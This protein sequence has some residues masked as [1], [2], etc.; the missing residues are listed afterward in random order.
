MNVNFV[1]FLKKN[2]LIKSKC[3]IVKTN[4]CIIRTNF[5]DQSVGETYHAL[6]CIAFLYGVLMLSE[7]QKERI[8]RL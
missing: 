1:V 7:G 2:C 5:V 6:K 4:N 8:R 3:E